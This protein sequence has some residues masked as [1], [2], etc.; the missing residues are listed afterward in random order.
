MKIVLA[1]GIYPPQIGGPATY[2]RALAE[3]LA[4]AGHDV[5]VLTFH[6]GGPVEADP[7]P[8]A[9]V[10]TSGGPLA[11]WR[12][13][14]STLRRDAADAD[15]V[16]AFS[17]VSAGVPLVLSRVKAPVRV[18]RLGGD[19]LWERATDRGSRTTLA[20]WYDARPKTRWLMQRLLL[21]F[22]HIVFSTAF[23]RALYE[24]HYVA[25]P[26][27]SVIENALPAGTP[28][29]HAAR[30]PLRLLFLGRFVPF[31]NLPALLAAMQHLPEATLTLAGDGPQQ[32][33]LSRLIHALGLGGRVHLR[34]AVSGAAKGAL[35]AEHDLLVIPSL[36]EISPNSALEA[37]A[38]GLP[39]LLTEETGLS[40]RLTEG[41]IVR[42]LRDPPAI[43][44]A[45]R[46][47]AADYAPAAR[48]ASAPPAARGWDVVAEEHLALFSRLTS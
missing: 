40:E 46:S 37:R 12:R 44:D 28:V 16:Y 32:T 29:A 24:R 8:V 41:M 39:V 26:E 9:R 18:L 7:W 5:R 3:R 25:L 11:R 35:F 47:I 4:A 45:V 22:D 34:A 2:V 43:A 21:A 33:E 1:T 20:E 23:Q 6:P 31:K 30:S 13:Y 19:F 42:A 10:P 36:T 14:A 38:A 48:A 15:V 17:S 27:T